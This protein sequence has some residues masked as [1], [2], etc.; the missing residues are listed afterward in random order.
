MENGQLGSL[1]HHL[2]TGAVGK[3]SRCCGQGL[4]VGHGFNPGPAQPSWGGVLSFPM[5]QSLWSRWL[6]SCGRLR[7]RLLLTFPLVT[8]L[9][10][11]CDIGPTGP[12]CIMATRLI[13]WIRAHGSVVLILFRVVFRLFRVLLP[14]VILEFWGLPHWMV[15]IQHS[16]SVWEHGQSRH[17]AGHLIRFPSVL[18]GKVL[19]CPADHSPAMC[20]WIL[21]TFL[22]PL[23]NQV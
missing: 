6:G 5:S 12:I 16:S 13:S 17:R 10:P 3:V 9:I 8:P 15:V 7:A 2:G 1:L 14:G 11:V 23:G 19:I 20:N 4:F 18:L 22:T 21:F